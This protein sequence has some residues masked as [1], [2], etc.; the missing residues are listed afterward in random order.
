M[1]SWLS[2]SGNVGGAEAMGVF[3]GIQY[4][5]QFRTLL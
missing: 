3:K 1:L 2:V 5:E 4:L